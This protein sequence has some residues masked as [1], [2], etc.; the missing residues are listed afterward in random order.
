[1]KLLPGVPDLKDKR[2]KKELWPGI[3]NSEL[4]IHFIEAKYLIKNK[5]AELAFIKLEAIFAIKSSYPK[6]DA[7]SS[8]VT[9]ILLSESVEK[10]DYRRA[11]HFLSREQKMFPKNEAAIRWR[12]RLIQIATDFVQQSKKYKQQGQPIKG[13]DA[14]QLAMKVWPRLPGLFSLFKKESN[15][16][17]ILDVG[18]FRAGGEP[19]NLAISAAGRVSSSL[20]HTNAHFSLLVM[21]ATAHLII[22]VGFL[23]NGSPQ[24]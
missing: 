8:Q 10:K 16:Y 11:R 5:Q 1:M 19:E 17:Q 23:K 22:R 9:E 13:V 14:L 15:R 6:L 24:I 18:I 4:G 21:S 7:L 12:N 2:K 20:A 3:I